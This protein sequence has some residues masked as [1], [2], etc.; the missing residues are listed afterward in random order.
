MQERG[1]L[2]PAVEEKNQRER[3][4]TLVAETLMLRVARAR[5]TGNER[6]VDQ[7]T[8]RG[9]PGR[10]PIPARAT[11]SHLQICMYARPPLASLLFTIGRQAAMNQPTY[12]GNSCTLINL[13]S[14]TKE[15]PPYSPTAV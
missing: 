8:D 3:G 14:K 1:K 12:S 4:E 15:I 11:L 9:G 2:A 5:E 10:V 7:G 6:L 13:A